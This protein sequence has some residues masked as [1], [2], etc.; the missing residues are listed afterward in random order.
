M[1][2]WSEYRLCWNNKKKNHSSEKYIFRHLVS[3]HLVAL[4]V[5]LAADLLRLL[6]TKREEKRRKFFFIISQLSAAGPIQPWVEERASDRLPAPCIIGRTDSCAQTSLFPAAPGMRIKGRQRRVFL[7]GGR[8]GVFPR[9]TRI[10]MS[11]TIGEV[12]DCGKGAAW[13]LSDMEIER[14]PVKM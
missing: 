12:D 1:G 11:P 6:I 7:F 14:P 4:C 2:Q 8:T 13:W 10:P 5:T 3:P 9:I